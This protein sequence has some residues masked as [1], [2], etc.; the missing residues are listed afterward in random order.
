MRIACFN[1]K[2]F[3]ILI[4]ESAYFSIYFSKLTGSVLLNKIAVINLAFIFPLEIKFMYSVQEKVEQFSKFSH[5]PTDAL[6]SYF[7]NQF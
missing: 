4:I 1:L 2:K 7:K 6:M 5:S 3:Y